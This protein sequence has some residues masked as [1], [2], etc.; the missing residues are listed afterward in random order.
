[1]LSENRE[2]K[3]PLRKYKKKYSAMFPVV[4][5]HGMSGFKKERK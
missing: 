3:I 1:M 2:K 5:R 4:C